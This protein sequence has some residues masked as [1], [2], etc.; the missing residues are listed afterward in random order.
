MEWGDEIFAFHDTDRV[1]NGRIEGTN[2]EL[3]VLKRTAYLWHREHRQLR[4]QIRVPRSPMSLSVM[5]WTGERFIVGW[6]VTPM[7]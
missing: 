4:R 5:G 2:N 1:T 3:G 7:V 6:S